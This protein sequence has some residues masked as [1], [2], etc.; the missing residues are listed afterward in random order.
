[1]PDFSGVRVSLKIPDITYYK[2]WSALRR[3][4]QEFLTPYEPQWAQNALTL[5]FYKKRLA[6]QKI[7]SDAKRG[8]FFF[9]FENNT[10]KLVGGINLNNIQYG[11]AYHASLGYWLGEEFQGQGYMGEALSLVTSYAFEDLRLKRL[12]AACLPDNARSV[13]LLEI[14]GFIEE[15]FAPKY[16]QINGVWQD[17]RLFGLINPDL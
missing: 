11:A 3:D 1:M 12:N 8:A 5:S 14:S 10:Q 17:H 2:E 13:C 4:N 16:L 9:V 6:R 7:E 15:G